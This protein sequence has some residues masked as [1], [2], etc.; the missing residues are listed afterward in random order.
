MNRTEATK[1]GDSGWY[2]GLLN[3]EREGQHEPDELVSVPSLELLRFRGEALRV[4]QMPV[5]T[6]AVFHGNEMTA[7]IDGEDKPLKFTTEDERKKLA[8]KQ[9]AQFAAEVQEAQERAK[10][11]QENK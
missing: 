11:E 6:V 5:G 8:E 7:L 3:D 9:R 2:L 10:A 1:D 4:L